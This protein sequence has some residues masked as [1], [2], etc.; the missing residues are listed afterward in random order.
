[1]YDCC[2]FRT[3]SHHLAV[4]ADF[5]LLSWNALILYSLPFVFYSARIAQLDDSNGLSLGR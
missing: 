3:R 2:M 5:N 1:M 4:A